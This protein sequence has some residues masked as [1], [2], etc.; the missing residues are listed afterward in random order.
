MKIS[1]LFLGTGFEETEAFGTVDVMRRAGMCV[2]MVSVS[3]SYEV[4]GAHNVTVK[5]DRLISEIKLTPDVDWLICPGGMPGATNLAASPELSDMLRKHNADGGHVAAICASPAVV[6]APLGIITGRRATC[7]PSFAPSVGTIAQ[8][9]GEPVVTD[10][11]VITG[12]GPANTFA[13]AL[14]IVAASLGSQAAGEVAQ[15]MLIN[16]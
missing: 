1:Y 5:A 8:M 11:N 7:Y 3:G 10:G 12:N 14:A 4:K 9:T 16:A 6:L 15:G 2:E 13:F